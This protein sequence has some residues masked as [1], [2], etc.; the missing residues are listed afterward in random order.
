MTLQDIGTDARHTLI[1]L[2]PDRRLTCIG[3]KTRYTFNQNCWLDW[4]TNTRWLRIWWTPI[5]GIPCIGL[6][7]DLINL[8]YLVLENKF[9]QFCEILNIEKEPISLYWREHGFATQPIQG[10]PCFGELLFYLALDSK[11]RNFL[12]PWN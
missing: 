4:Y 12:F 9:R 7:A 5:Q 1:A 10:Q 8:S 2:A 6:N 11:T 3:S